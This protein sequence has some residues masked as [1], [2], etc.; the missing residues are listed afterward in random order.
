MQGTIIAWILIP[1]C[2]DLFSNKFFRAS[3]SLQQSS[4]GEIAADGEVW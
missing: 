3:S 4:T 1:G 2:L